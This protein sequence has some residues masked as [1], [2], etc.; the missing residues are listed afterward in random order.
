MIKN[1]IILD[2]N[3][4]LLFF[5][6]IDIAERYMEPEDIKNN[7]YIAYDGEGR[8]LKLELAE[9]ERSIFFGFFKVTQFKVKILSTERIPSH[10][11]ELEQKLLEFLQKI[12]EDNKHDIKN[13]LA[14]L[15]PRAI[16]LSGYCEE[17]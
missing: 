16:E 10:K 4:N 2:E 3:G 9:N 17:Q 1:P 14:I 6:S 7:E 13:S 11:Q 5:R 12:S 15:L 8:L